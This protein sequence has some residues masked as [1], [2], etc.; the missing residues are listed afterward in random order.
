MGLEV[1]IGDDQVG[2]RNPN[3]IYLHAGAW[4]GGEYIGEVSY[5]KKPSDDNERIAY[6]QN[7]AELLAKMMERFPQWTDR[8]VHTQ[9]LSFLNGTLKQ[10]GRE[11]KVSPISDKMYKAFITTLLDKIY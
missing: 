6:A 9:K 5:S 10:P 8:G 1:Y 4:M 3:E 11:L 7:L 2:N